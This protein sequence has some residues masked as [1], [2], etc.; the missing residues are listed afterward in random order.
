M[1]EQNQNLASDHSQKYTY[2]FEPKKISFR[3][4]ESEFAMLKQS[5]EALPIS[6]P[7]SVKAKAQNAPLVTPKVAPDLSQA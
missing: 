2:R 4:C 7:A 5:A 1:S 6:V 3:V